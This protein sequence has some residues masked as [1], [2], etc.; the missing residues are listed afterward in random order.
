MAPVAQMYP[1]TTPQY[2]VASPPAI[3]PV[4]T[5]NRGLDWNSIVQHNPNVGMS[6]NA[7][8]GHFQQQ[9]YIAQNAFQPA[10]FAQGMPPPQQSYTQMG[11]YQQ[12]MNMGGV[13]RNV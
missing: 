5:T 2:M 12:P 3:P 6:G 7:L 13:N 1:S 11:G 9:Q 10:A 4:R 8:G